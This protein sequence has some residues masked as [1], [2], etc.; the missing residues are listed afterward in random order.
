MREDPSFFVDVVGDWSEQSSTKILSETRKVHPDLTSA[1]GKQ[2]F[3]NRTIISA[4]NEIHENL[5]MWD[6]VSKRIDIIMHME[7]QDDKDDDDDDQFEDAV[8]E[9]KLLLEKRVIEKMQ[10]ELGFILPSSPPMRSMFQRSE[11]RLSLRSEL[12]KN[13]YLLFLG[14]ELW[15]MKG[16]VPQEIL[17]TEINRMIQPDNPQKDRVTPMVARFFANL[18]PAYELRSRLRRLCPQLF[19]P[20]NEDQEADSIALKTWAKDDEI[21]ALYDLKMI[22][23]PSHAGNKFLRLGILEIRRNCLT[24]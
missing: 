23:S 8:R 4:I 16:V 3:W 24:P 7:D 5:I 14:R 11:G 2:N 15:E 20:E 12:P 13:D 1:L 9:L 21:L 18:G 19:G 10:R 22:A 17:A 6:I